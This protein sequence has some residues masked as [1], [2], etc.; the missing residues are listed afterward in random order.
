M[1]SREEILEEL[2]T[3]I[4]NDDLPEVE[5][6][7]KWKA[8]TAMSEYAR[9]VAVEFDEWKLKNGWRYSVVGAYVNEAEERTIATSE[10]FELFI[11][12]NKKG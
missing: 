11:N 5:A 2:G 3:F 9:E 1:K 6:I 7:Y 12:E 10:L 8:S 4:V